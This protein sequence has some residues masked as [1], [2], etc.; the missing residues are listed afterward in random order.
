MKI[1]TTLLRQ[2]YIVIVVNLSSVGLG[3]TMAWNSPMLYKLMYEDTQLSHRITSSD[4]SWIVSI[5]YL[6]A[7]FFCPLTSWVLDPMGRKLCL[8]AFGTIRATLGLI[9]VFGTEVW[10]LLVARAINGIFEIGILMILPSYCVEISSKEIRGALGTISQM[11]SSVGMLIM[12]GF[13]PFLSYL[14]VN[15]IYVVALYATVIPLLF[16]PDSPYSLLRK[17]LKD[18]AF[19]VLKLLRGSEMA[20]QQELKEM[21]VV[22]GCQVKVKDLLK[23]RIFL[24]ALS[25]S[26][27]LSIGFQLIGYSAVTVYLQSIMDITKTSVSSN[28]ISV[29]F[30]VMQII[31]SLVSAL[32]S[33][34]AGRKIILCVTLFGTSIGMAGL[35]LFFYANDSSD[36]IVGFMNYLPIVS[37][38][39]IVLC[40]NA[41][42][43][44]LCILVC[45]ELFDSPARTTS[46]SISV[47]SSLIFA[48]LNLK[49]FPLL[50]ELMGAAAVFWSF[51]AINL[52]YVLF[53]MFCVPETKRKSFLEIQRALG[54]REDKKEAV[55]A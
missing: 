20:A 14:N 54:R 32:L 36:S 51:S 44:S 22:H 40:Y 19:E 34:K 47:S 12:F 15:I 29:I 25:I 9:L 53:I 4:A 45:T 55:C 10:M 17:G 2:L 11:A 38:I 31:A 8:L 30:G 43:G 48:F 23:D 24:K 50:S 28:T 18:E 35:G 1:S 42:M 3:L 39:I 13:G 21:T 37:V 7:I 41:G 52:L 33:D 49:Y 16:V 5:G 6:A 27:L 46:V 26:V